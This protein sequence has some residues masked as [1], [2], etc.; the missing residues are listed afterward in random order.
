MKHYLLSLLALISI[1]YI[2]TDQELFLPELNQQELELLEKNPETIFVY[3][4][5]EVCNCINAIHQITDKKNSILTTIDTLITNNIHVLEFDSARACIDCSLSFLHQNKDQLDQETCANIIT[6]LEEYKQNLDTDIVAQESD[7]KRGPKLAFNLRVIKNLQSNKLRVCDTACIIGLLTAGNAH[8]RGNVIIDGN[9]IV[10]GTFPS[11]ST[12]TIITTGTSSEDLL[13]INQGGNSYAA[14]IVIGSLDNNAM[15][16]I[17][18]GA[19]QVT[20]LSNTAPTAGFVGIGTTIPAQQLQITKNFEL[21]VTTAAPIGIIYAGINTLIHDFDASSGNTNFFA[22]LNA[23]NLT[24]NSGATNNTGVGSSALNSLTGGSQNTAL[25]FQSLKANTVGVENNA[26]GHQALLK[27]TNGSDNVAVGNAALSNNISGNENNAIGINALLNN[28]GSNNIAIGVSAL[29]A[30]T[31]GAG[32]T[33]VGTQAL[34][35]AVGSQN[36]GIGNN[37]FAGATTGTNNIGIGSGTL[38]AACVSNNIAIGNN[39]LSVNTTSNNTAVGS[40][41]LSGSTSGTQNTAVGSNALSGSTSGTQNIA[42]G[43]NSFLGNNSGTLNIGI[44]VGTLAGAGGAGNGSNN[45]AINFNALNANTSGSNNIAIGNLAL[46]NNT[47]GTQNVAVG[48]SALQSNIVGF[49]NT[50]IGTNALIN[51]AP[52][53]PGGGSDNIALGFNA[54][55][56]Y[57]STE[58]NNIAIGNGGLVTESNVIRIGTSGAGTGQQN[59]CFIAGIRGITTGVAD[60]IAVLIDS[61]GQLGT[62]SSSQRFKENIQDMDTKSN[63]IMKLRPVVFNWKKDEKKSLQFGF[64]AE[65]VAEKMPELVVYDEEGKPFTI[66]YHD[67]PAMLLNEMQKLHKEINHLKKEI[68]C[69]KK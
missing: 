65:E 66:R 56:A 46:S 21:P 29:S 24:M 13:D 38:G 31:S 10:N 33:A 43:Y 18:T 47:T 49:Q 69:L 67:M 22:G 5:E 26:I 12:T 52:I 3:I 48:V 32:S 51:L 28:T 15:N 60:A 17:T 63:P 54:G 20:I 34:S 8:F 44:G 30:N 64:I 27:N 36:I 7:I 58:S 42:V 57:T 68:A 41:A 1:C 55:N 4:P 11:T 9:L 61:N 53:V 45:I 37:S 50:A 16:F 23:G 40:S 25:G 35:N 59:K 2:K 19:T 39:A 14:P 6:I 62:V